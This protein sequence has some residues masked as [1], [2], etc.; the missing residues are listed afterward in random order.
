MTSTLEDRLRRAFARPSTSAALDDDL[1]QRLTQRVRKARSRRRATATVGV[2]AVIAGLVAGGAAWQPWVGD[3]S[4]AE[5]SSV[6]TG[7][8]DDCTQVRVQSRGQRDVQGAQEIALVAINRAQKAVCRIPADSLD[9]SI[10]QAPAVVGTVRFTGTVEVAPTE[11]VLFT[12]K[13]S[14]WCSTSLPSVVIAGGGLNLETRTNE[15]PECEDN[16]RP[17]RLVLTE[18][19]TNVEAQRNGEEP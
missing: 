13:W 9:L 11:S 5:D 7:H 18:A 4:G 16:S 6:A 17:S 10:P 19:S 12:M 2:G 15:S 14:N 1:P 3:P 8:S